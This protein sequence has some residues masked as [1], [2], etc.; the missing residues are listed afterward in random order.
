[1]GF[2]EAEAALAAPGLRV[3]IDF[4]ARK[5]QRT[6][7]RIAVLEEELAILRTQAGAAL[8][9]DQVSGTP[10]EHHTGSSPSVRE[11]TAA[12]HRKLS[13]GELMEWVERIIGGVGRPITVREITEAL[14]RPTRGKAGR[15]PLAT[16]RV[17]C[18]R[19][20]QNGRVI[21]QPVGYFAIVGADRPERT[22]CG[23]RRISRCATA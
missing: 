14:G 13:S 21:E 22:S 16:V 7:A 2:T 20:A 5:V 6:M 12:G 4:Y 17:T 18:K 1:M 11:R 10:I 19:M 9:C 23:S 8:P 3:A 15:G